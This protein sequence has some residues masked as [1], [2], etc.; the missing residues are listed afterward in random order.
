M[1]GKTPEPWEDKNVQ[2]SSKRIGSPYTYKGKN[3]SLNR[4]SE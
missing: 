2:K 4:A 3:Q 1:K